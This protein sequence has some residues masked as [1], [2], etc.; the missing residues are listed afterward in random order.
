M[1]NLKPNPMKKIFTTVAVL[2]TVISICVGLGSWSGIEETQSSCGAAAGLANDPA[3]GSQN[4]TNC[5]S[6][7]AAIPRT[8]MITSDI[9]G[10]GYYPGATYTFSATIISPGT[11]TFGFE[12]TCQNATGT[13]MLGTLIP[14]G[15]VETQ[16]K[17]LFIAPDTFKYITHK[18][19]S[20]FGS[21]F[22]TW[23]Y[24]WKAPPQGSGT[25]S[26]F[27]SFNAADGSGDDTGDSIFI[28][29]QTFDEDLSGI[30]P[31]YSETSIRVFPSISN[32]TFTVQNAAFKS[33]TYELSIYN[34]AG[35]RV[36]EKSMSSKIE[37]LDL[38][39]KS[40]LYFVYFKTDNITIVRKIII[41]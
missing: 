31:Q 22:K 28:T 25:V 15:N 33:P 10:T 12:N 35:E 26:F 8:G 1:N 40:G 19:T 39:V 16:L 14:I 9:P 29:S 17:T 23:T 6:D 7:Y 2:V 32:G 30:P 11:T 13:A 34:V 37:T 3:N 27:G 18:C 24:S 20:N 4:C 36:F 38:N 21:G 41:Q 5:H